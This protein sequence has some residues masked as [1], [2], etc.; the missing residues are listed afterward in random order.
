MAFTTQDFKRAIDFTGIP[1]AS[2]ADHNNLIDLSYP[3]SDSASEGKGI[4]VW[5]IDS[6]LNTPRVPSPMVV[7]NKVKRYGW[8]RIPYV[9]ATSQKPILYA[10]NDNVASDPTYL[11]WLD[12][13]ADLT[14]INAAIAALTISLAATNATAVNA[15]VTASNASTTANQAS[16]DA[17]DAL[18]TATAASAQAT[19]AETDAQTGIANA[20]AAQ[21]TANNALAAISAP[22]ALNAAITPGTAGQ[23]IRTLSDASAPEWYDEINTY[24]KVSETQNIGVDAGGSANGVNQRQLNTEDNDAG[25]LAAIAGGKI[26]LQAGIYKVDIRVGSRCDEPNQAFLVKDSDNTKLIKGTTCNNS[27]GNATV[28]MS[29]IIGI[30]TLAAATTLRIDHY[31]TG[32]RAVSGLGKAAGLDTEV[33]VTAE[34]WKLN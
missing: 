11:C 31:F 2:G 20:A 7:G 29:H 24:V 9:T 18:T 33:Y 17:T 22:R 12:T 21:T 13:A 26:T 16:I 30:V 3:N 5:S 1:L 34:F 28:Q 19:Q 6:A 25:N 32:A 14:T 10:W 8:L 4:F 27:S 15:N 23:H